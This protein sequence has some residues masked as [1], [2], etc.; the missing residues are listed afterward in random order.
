MSVIGLE[1]AFREEVPDCVVYFQTTRY[2][3]RKGAEQAEHNGQNDD[4]PAFPE[5]GLKDPFQRV[6]VRI[7]R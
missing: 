2:R 6:L 4:M 3:Q 5:D 7:V 1:V